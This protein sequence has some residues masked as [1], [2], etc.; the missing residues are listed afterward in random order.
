L[1]VVETKKERRKK[2]YAGSENQS[3]YRIFWAATFALARYIPT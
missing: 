1:K 3:R 2:N